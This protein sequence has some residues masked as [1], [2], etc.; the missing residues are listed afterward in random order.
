MLLIK[1]FIPICLQ[2]I[3]YLLILKEKSLKRRY[4]VILVTT[5]TNVV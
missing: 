2:K 3:N 1:V 5:K 4:D